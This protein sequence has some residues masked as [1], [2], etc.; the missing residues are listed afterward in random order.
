MCDCVCV[1]VGDDG[2]LTLPQRLALRAGCEELVELG[3]ASYNGA[4]FGGNVLGASGRCVC[5]CMCVFIYMCVCMCVC[6]CVCMYGVGEA[7]GC[8]VRVWKVCVY[9]CLCV[10]ACMEWE[11]LVEL[12]S[13]SY[14]WDSFGREILGACGMCVRVCVC[15]CVCMYGVQGVAG[16]GGCQQRWGCFGGGVSRRVR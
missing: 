12:G 14:D 9:A 2:N 1:C 4:S 13:A 8:S 15:V 11:E 16:A 6:I 3:S 10:C 5:V 7:G